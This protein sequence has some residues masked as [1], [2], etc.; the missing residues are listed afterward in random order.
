[1]RR[2]LLV[3]AAFIA[4]AAIYILTSSNKKLDQAIVIPATDETEKAAEIQNAVD[5]LHGQKKSADELKY[6]RAV[7]LSL[8]SDDIKSKA[9]AG[10]IIAQRIYGS[11]LEECFTYSVSKK[12]YK[13]DLDARG[14]IAPELR[15]LYARFGAKV[16]ARC[17]NFTVNMPIH[18][19]DAY[20][21]Y[22]LAAMKKD[23]QSMA[24]VL[25][26]MGV[27]KLDD[28]SLNEGVDFIIASKDPD[29]MM[30]LANVMGAHN[31]SRAS[32]LGQFSGSERNEYAWRLAAC[33]LGADC[34][35]NAQIVTNFCLYGGAIS[36]CTGNGLQ[37]VIRRDVLAPREYEA[38]LNLSTEIINSLPR[39]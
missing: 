14:K 18:I 13:E 23:A 4:F 21:W 29:A 32:A 36:A 1:M 37:E 20:L 10:D 6:E 39:P 24:K 15:D 2:S 34:S 7:D 27:E 11:M 38:A 17:K 28:G 3:L 8:I 12:T 22:A 31:Q 35:A 9:E 19:K 33:R 25:T 30:E 5:G 16:E 26:R